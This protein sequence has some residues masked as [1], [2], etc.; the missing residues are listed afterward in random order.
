[1][2]SFNKNLLIK[3][4]LM[5]WPVF[6]YLL[7]QKLPRKANVALGFSQYKKLLKTLKVAHKLPSTIYLGL[8]SV[9]CPLFTVGT[10]RAS[11]GPR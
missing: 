3:I 9:P 8:V 7:I 2:T 1:M 10:V 4:F 11:G 6:N 5:V